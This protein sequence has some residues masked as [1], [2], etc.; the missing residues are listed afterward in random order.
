MLGGLDLSLSLE[1]AENRKKCS[2][3]GYSFKFMS[4][5]GVEVVWLLGA[6]RGGYPGF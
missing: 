6:F 3:A 4:G 5:I 2:S 1:E